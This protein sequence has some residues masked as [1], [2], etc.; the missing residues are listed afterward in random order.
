MSEENVEIVRR[1]HDVFYA[2]LRGELSREA[3]AELLDPQ[4]EY[5]WHDQQTYP[6]F[7]QHLRGAPALIEFGEQYRRTWADLAASQRELIEAPGDRALAS[8]SQSAR[9]RESDVPIVIHYFQVWTI[10]DRN[11]RKVENFRHRADA[12]EAAGLEE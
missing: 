10:R 6:D 7:P 9:G 1:S 8:I 5:R 11:V 3:L 4:I 2:F 12:L